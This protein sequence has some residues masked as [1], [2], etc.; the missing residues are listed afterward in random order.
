M[1]SARSLGVLFYDVITR[2]RGLNEPE[3]RSFWDV[4]V[5]Q[6]RKEYQSDVTESYPVADMWFIEARRNSLVH[7]GQ[8]SL[9]GIKL[10]YVIPILSS[11][12]PL[13]TG[14]TR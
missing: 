3:T 7:F 9:G 10:L 11:F 12:T 6:G 14:Y 4:I 5:S 1:L 13:G 8:G 2:K